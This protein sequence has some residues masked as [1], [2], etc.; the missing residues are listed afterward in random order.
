M[1]NYYLVANKKDRK[2]ERNPHEWTI[3]YRQPVSIAVT[4]ICGFLLF[5][6][7][8]SLPEKSILKSLMDGFGYALVVVAAFGRIWSTLYISG[9]KEDRVVLEGPYAIIRNPLYVFSFLGAM[10]MG[11]VTNNLLILVT[12]LSAFI[13]YYRLVV[14]AEEKNLQEKFGQTYF[15][16][17]CRVPRFI[18]R[19]FRLVEPDTYPVR[20]RHVRRSLQQIMWFFWILLILYGIEYVHRT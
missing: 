2:V 4:I 19:A 11:L 8:H 20:P 14:L 10:G 1:E 17:T 6:T 12:L 15:E 7:P 16:Y 9:Y 13:L 18:P 5:L 3:K